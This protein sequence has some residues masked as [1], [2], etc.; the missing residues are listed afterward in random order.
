MNRTLVTTI[1]ALVFW[2][3]QS[4]YA[5]AVD[6]TQPPPEKLRIERL[7]R[8]GKLW[9]TVRYIHP[10]LGYKDLDWD[11]PLIK[12]IPKVETAKTKD[13]YAAAIGEMLAALG[14]KA[15]TVV[16]QD[17]VGSPTN[18]ESQPVWSRLE[19]KILV[20]RITNYID[21]ERQ[22]A[23]ARTRIESLKSEINKAEGIIF[24]IR[25]LTPGTQ[26]G[27]MSAVFEPIGNWLVCHE[28]AG[29][30]EQSLLHS[31]YKPRV[32]TTSGGYFSAFLIPA[33]TNFIPEPGAKVKRVAF[34]INARSELPH[35]A[36][37]LQS[38]GDGALISEGPISDAVY[39]TTT[40][41]DLGEGVSARV[42]TT[43]YVS[44]IGTGE[45]RSNLEVAP[46]PDASPSIPSYEFSAEVRQTGPRST[47]SGPVRALA[48]FC[49]YSTRRQDV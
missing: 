49:G 38:C 5:L 27:I 36:M 3:T 24:D 44:P 30:A 14:D 37:A 29:P 10:F 13:E 15:T 43:E 20:V 33:V 16:R 35:V 2:P 34:I 39:V 8:L 21:L 12:A 26:S 40:S 17:A 18:G 25:A 48:R 19:D 1:A 11:A 46:S 9:G 31:G 22:F 4:V 41:V 6:D 28:V 23:A 32:G 42:R 47:R 45:I 7:S